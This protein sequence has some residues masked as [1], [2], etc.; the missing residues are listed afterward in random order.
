MTIQTSIDN[1]SESLT[2][3]TF[4]S[5]ATTITAG[6]GLVAT[7]GGVTATGNSS[8]SSGTFTV[9]SGTNAI[10]ISADAAATTV[11]LATGGGVKTTT[12]GSTNTTSVTTVACGT[13][14]ANFGT[15]A[16]AHATTVGST[17][18]S[19][20]TTIQGPSAGVFA[21]GVAGVSVANLNVVT[22]NTS[23]GALGSQAAAS[24]DVTSASNLTDNAVV[25]GDGGAKGVQTSTM[26]ISDAGEMTNPSQPAFGAT[27]SALDSNVTGDGTDFTIGSG[28]AWTERFDQNAD[29]NTNGTFT[30]PVTG[31][32]QFN[33]S[34]L[35]LD[36]ISTMQPLIDINTSNFNYVLGNDGTAFTGNME[37]AFSVLA[38]M[39]TAD[40]TQFHVIVGGGTKTVDVL[41]GRTAFSGFLA[42]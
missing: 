2:T 36:V 18:A 20:T 35:M 23:T 7:T 42:C 12:L 11:N 30:A 32:Y 19:A 16:N 25:R 39:D 15:S 17:T 41:D 8:I 14:G 6:T 3:N 13:G 22:I 5:A 26:L 10:N 37:M 9:A 40:I 29:F 33:V 1:K 34:I 21:V 27:L 31:R 4:V 28:N 24:G 38:D